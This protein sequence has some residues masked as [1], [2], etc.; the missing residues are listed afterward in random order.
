[1]KKII[2]ALGIL[3]TG[4]ISASAQKASVIMND[5]TGW[6]KIAETTVNFEKEKDEIL[7]LG[8][9]RFASIRFKVT[10][11]PVELKKLEV[12]Y[13]SGDNQEINVNKVI[14]MG[15]ESGNIDLNGGER[16]LKKVV[17]H[18]HTVPNTNDKKA[19]LELWGLKTNP[20]KK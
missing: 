18:Y 7:V 13:E 8:A 20:D 16:N 5:R 14:L 6:H 11:A 15:R 19:H 1:M 10:D 9:D 2:L 3:L 12:Y 17:F 4:C